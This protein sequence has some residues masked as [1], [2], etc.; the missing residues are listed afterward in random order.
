[1]KVNL[2]G[3]ESKMLVSQCPYTALMVLLES[4]TMGTSI[5]ETYT[6][7]QRFAAVRGI[8]KPLLVADMIR[9]VY[10]SSIAEIQPINDVDIF[11]V[12]L[13]IP[14]NPLKYAAIGL[15]PYEKY[16]ATDLCSLEHT[17]ERNEDG[18]KTNVRKLY[19]GVY[20]MPNGD[21]LYLFFMPD[22][23]RGGNLNS[24]H[25]DLCVEYM[26]HCG[27][28]MEAVCGFDYFYDKD[29]SNNPTSLISSGFP[30]LAAPLHVFQISSSIDVLIMSVKEVQDIDEE[31]YKNDETYRELLDDMVAIYTDSV[32]LDDIYDIQRR[33]LRIAAI[34]YKLRNYKSESHANSYL[35][36]IGLTREMIEKG[37]VAQRDLLERMFNNGDLADKEEGEED[38]SNS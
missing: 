18:K 10:L 26:L 8:N 28:F 4:M 7:A 15:A 36:S 23:F 20:T 13:N 3:I 12:E 19:K 21:L 11:Y 38:G 9:N 30:S 27:S 6:A 37:E 16:V 17:Y 5:P 29:R 31:L 1:M 2:R 34:N 24:N 35:E 25:Q 22:K 33:T 14:T 32:Y